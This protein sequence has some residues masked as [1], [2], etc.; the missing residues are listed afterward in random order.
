[1]DWQAYEDQNAN[2]VFSYVIASKLEF[3]EILYA[4]GP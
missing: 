3:R 2:P 4:R 1:M